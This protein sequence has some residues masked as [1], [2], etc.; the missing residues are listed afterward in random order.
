MASFFDTTLHIALPEF[1]FIVMGI[2]IIG[3]A[4]GFLWIHR[5]GGEEALKL[6][7]KKEEEE[8]DKWR[9]KFYDQTEANEKQLGELTENLNT[10]QEKEEQLAVE[11]EEL[12]L[13]N[14]QLMLK[15]KNN[16]AQ[17]NVLVQ[18]LDIFKNNL[19]EKEEIILQLREENRLLSE[20]K[21]NERIDPDLIQALQQELAIAAR[22]EQIISDKFNQPVNKEDTIPE[23]LSEWGAHKLRQELKKLSQKNN[24]LKTQLARLGYIEENTLNG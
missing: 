6:K 17:Q 24:Y 19:Q 12:T 1:I 3:F 23:G 7:L 18:E 20:K 5:K 14:Q 16:T 10:L 13:L 15:Q 21:E 22:L 9:L 8:T 11:V 4:I 2:V